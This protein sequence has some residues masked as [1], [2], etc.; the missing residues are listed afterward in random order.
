MIAKKRKYS[1]DYLQYGFTDAIGNGQVVPQCIVCFQV[2]SNDALRPTRLQ[3]H[4]Q[5]KHSCHQDKPLAFFLKQ[6]RFTKKN[7]DCK[8]GNLLPVTIG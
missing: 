8:Q 2:L 6:E 7:E 1:E 4:L 5:T 3:R